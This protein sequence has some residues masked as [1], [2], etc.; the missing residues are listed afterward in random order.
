MIRQV[1][2]AKL[3]PA[4]DFVLLR[5]CY[6]PDEGAI[7]LP[8]KSRDMTFWC[9]IEAVGP[10]CRHLTAADVGKYCCGHQLKNGQFDLGDAWY[11]T[12]EKNIDFTLDEAG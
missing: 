5:Q 10:K 1:D 11:C 2:P 8:D 3:S 12:R 4:N 6:R 9:V 7:V